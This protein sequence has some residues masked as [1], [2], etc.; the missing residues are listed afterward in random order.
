MDFVVYNDKI[1]I[2]PM[3]QN[4]IMVLDVETGC[5][6]KV[7]YIADILELSHCGCLHKNF[8]CI[9]SVKGGYVFTIDLNTYRQ[10]T[11]EIN[12]MSD[13]IV[14]CVSYGESIFLLTDKG[15]IYRLDIVE[16]TMLKIYDFELS[17]PAHRIVVTEHKIIV[18]PY[19]Q[20]HDI[21]ILDKDSMASYVYKDYPEDFCYQA[22]EGWSAYEGMTETA[23]FYLYAMRTA[24]YALLVNKISGEMQWIHPRNIDGQAM[25][26]MAERGK[27][28]FFEEDGYYGL[29]DI[30]GY[31]LG[32]NERDTDKLSQSGK[33]KDNYGMRIYDQTS[34]IE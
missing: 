26:I 6:E 13:D 23:N 33:S 2:F 17:M 18:L 29:K 14:H 31:V 8:Y 30:I 16:M 24:N 5:S 20:G 7:A 15:K 12:E 21:C 9:F 1:L 25:R 34:K 22:W 3:H 28:V 32:I 19:Y 27:R 4:E 11:F 10:Q